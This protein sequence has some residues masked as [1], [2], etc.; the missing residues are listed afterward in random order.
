MQL[1]SEALIDINRARYMKWYLE[2]NFYERLKLCLDYLKTHLVKKAWGIEPSQE[3]LPPM[4]M[5]EQADKTGTFLYVYVEGLDAQHLQQDRYLAEFLLFIKLHLGGEQYIEYLLSA[6]AKVLHKSVTLP[7]HELN[8]PVKSTG[9]KF[10]QCT[11]IDSK[12]ENTQA[13][14]IDARLA[15]FIRCLLH[16]TNV[17][18]GL[19]L[20]TQFFDC[21]MTSCNMMGSRFDK[22]TLL[23]Q[24]NIEI[25]IFLFS[26]YQDRDLTKDDL[27]R[28]GALKVDQA[29]V[30]IED[31]YEALNHGS[32]LLDEAERLFNG[33][34]S[35]LH[36]ELFHHHFFSTDAQKEIQLLV[37]DHKK[38]QKL[39][40]YYLRFNQPNPQDDFL[41]IAH[42][43][44]PELLICLFQDACPQEPPMTR[45]EAKAILQKSTRVFTARKKL[46]CLDLTGEELNYNL[47][48]KLYPHAAPEAVV[49]SLRERTNHT[50]LRLTSLCLETIKNTDCRMDVSPELA[51][52][53]PELETNPLRLF[54]R[55]LD[56][57]LRKYQPNT[58]ESRHLEALYSCLNDNNVYNALIQ[59]LSRLSKEEYTSYFKKN[60]ISPLTVLLKQYHQKKLSKA[61][62]SE[63]IRE[64]LARY[65]PE[66]RELAYLRY[67]NYL[68][69]NFDKIKDL[70]TA[71]QE[72]LIE[73]R[74]DEEH[75]RV[76]QDLRIPLQALLSRYYDAMEEK[77]NLSIS[78]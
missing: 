71:L 7:A 33:L 37:G 19:F 2:P 20:G 3:S 48:Q 45:R 41:R 34:R 15:C 28:M 42:L 51:A 18:K 6:T 52:I 31:F 23:Y 50:R 16:K 5:T 22:T 63:K 32:L 68:Q 4:V 46:L 53:Y 75:P 69:D 61:E 27:R 12:F 62:L 60:L 58:K 64:Q 59:C 1:A 29:I 47:F 24:C 73:H 66:F 56:E 77:T 72:Y 8:Q 54:R 35:R 36:Q 9:P 30:S 74:A 25:A 70:I 26:K 13:S 11:F 49:A 44:K 67:L 55:G 76:Q 40:K 10:I 43:D 14:G 78:M 17:E 65:L 57:F 21:N 39:G 38:L